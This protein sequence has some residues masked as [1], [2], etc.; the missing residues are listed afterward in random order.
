M[1]KSS[2]LLILPFAAACAQSAEMP[3]P[4]F[5]AGSCSDSRLSRFAGQPSSAQLGQTMLAASGAKLLRWVPHGSV[6]T[7]ELREDRLTV[8]LDGQGKVERAVCA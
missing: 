5:G 7:M 1:L 4:V 6:I 3:P 8:H 2:P